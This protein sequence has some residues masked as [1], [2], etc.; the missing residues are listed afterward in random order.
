MFKMLQERSV[1]EERK[2][3]LDEQRNNMGWWER[4]E[5]IKRGEGGREGR[6]GKDGGGKRLT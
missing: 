4:W 2:E 6:K 3:N 5:N 1:M